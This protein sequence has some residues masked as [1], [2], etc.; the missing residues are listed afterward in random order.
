M[1]RDDNLEELF[2][3]YNDETIELLIIS[4]VYILSIRANL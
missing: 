2:E 1:N 4:F 3:M